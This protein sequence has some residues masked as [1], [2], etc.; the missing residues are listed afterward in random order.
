M[1][2]RPDKYGTDQN[3]RVAHRDDSGDG[4]RLWHT[5]LPAYSGK[6]HRDNVRAA[7]PDQG[8]ADQ[9]RGPAIDSK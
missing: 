2:D 1:G 3:A 6:E 5:L 7:S 4:Y 8:V 9:G